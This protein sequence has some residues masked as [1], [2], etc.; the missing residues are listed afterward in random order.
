MRA[1]ASI[2]GSVATVPAVALPETSGNVLSL[3]AAVHVCMATLLFILALALIQLI[4]VWELGIHTLAHS[5][6]IALDWKLFRVET[7]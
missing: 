1:S 4:G 3:A 7:L 6:D 2:N 5:A